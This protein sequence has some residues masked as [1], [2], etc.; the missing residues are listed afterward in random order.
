MNSPHITFLLSISGVF[1]EPMCSSTKLDHG[2]L[3]VGYGT[4]D[5]SDYWLIKN[6]FEILMIAYL[7]LKIVILSAVFINQLTVIDI[8]RHFALSVGELAGEWKALA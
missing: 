8:C 7:S 6:R 5:G 2:I 3:A 1:N 4:N